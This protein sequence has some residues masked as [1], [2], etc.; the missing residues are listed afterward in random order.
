MES[1]IKQQRRDLHKVNQQVVPSSDQSKVTTIQGQDQIPEEDSS[2]YSDKSSKG[3]GAT[4]QLD[5][6]LATEVSQKM[7][8]IMNLNQAKWHVNGLKLISYQEQRIDQ[9]TNKHVKV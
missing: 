8:R 7:H 9:R 5:H 1:L 6:A 3:I 4:V 2:I